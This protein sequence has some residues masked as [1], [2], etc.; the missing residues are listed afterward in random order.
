MKSIDKGEYRSKMRKG[1]SFYFG[2]DNNIEERVKMI[3][4]AGFDSVMTNADKK[5]N[6]QNGTIKK[7]C[8]LFK[9]YG[10]KLS[11][12][13][14]Q[15]ENKNLHYFWESGE[16]GEKLKKK[17]IKDIKIAKKYGF[18]CVVVHLKGEYSKIGEKRL[19]EV[20]EVCSKLNVM[21]A[22]EN[23]DCQSVFLE[24]FKNI[25]HDMLKFCYDSGH[26]NVFDKD[27]DYLELFKDKLITLHLHDND[28]KIDQ[29]TLNKFGSINWDDIAKKLAKCNNVLDVI[30]LDYE[31]LCKSGELIDCQE[32]LLE[33]K[34]QAD[35]LEEKIINYSSK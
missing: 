14:F 27:F 13:H 30:S 8:K 21:L 33:I 24:T 4:D 17:L 35:E 19:N 22:I 15:Y 16:F 2:F 5:F 7:Q 31:V 32:C 3:K 18:S 9:K 34:K 20:L 25:K 28:G 23:I 10:L 29:H 11:S 12:L 6:H 26:N 1:I